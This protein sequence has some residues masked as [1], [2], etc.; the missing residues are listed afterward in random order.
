MFVEI[1]FNEINIPLSFIFTG[2]HSYLCCHHIVHKFSC[3]IA[4][5]ALGF[6]HK[7]DFYNS[8]Q[9]SPAIN[10]TVS[11]VAVTSARRLSLMTESRSLLDSQKLFGW[12][13]AN[14]TYRGRQVRQ[15]PGTPSYEVLRHCGNNW[16]CDANYN[17]KECICKLYIVL[18]CTLINVCEPCPRPKMF[19]DYH[20]WEVPG[21]KLLACLRHQIINL[22]RSPTCPRWVLDT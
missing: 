22:S 13:V 9:F 4:A 14:N 3:L 1:F 16:K 17:M 20:F 7:S 10:Y 15:L 2:Q 8:E 19:N 12:L 21:T 5:C 6:F 11:K 18:A